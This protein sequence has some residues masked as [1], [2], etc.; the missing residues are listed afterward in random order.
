VVGFTFAGEWAVKAKK[1]RFLRNQNR[2][3]TACLRA[4]FC[5]LGHPWRMKMDGPRDTTGVGWKPCEYSVVKELAAN[6][7]N[8]LRRREI[9]T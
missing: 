1:R 8:T 7:S 4:R 2:G 5:L 3:G 9:G 6:A